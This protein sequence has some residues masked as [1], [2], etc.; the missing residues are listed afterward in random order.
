V[1]VSSSVNARRRR[2]SR[3][4]QQIETKKELDEAACILAIARVNLEVQQAAAN[5]QAPDVVEPQLVHAPV[6]QQQAAQSTKA[7]AAE[8]SSTT[9]QT[10]AEQCIV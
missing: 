4:R 10:V 5:K 2:F 3:G 9:S 8:G 1:T 6:A 7:T